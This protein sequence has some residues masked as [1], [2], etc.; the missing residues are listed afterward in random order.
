MIDLIFYLLETGVKLAV[1]VVIGLM[2]L[3]GLISWLNLNPFGWFAYNVRR[4]TEPMVDPLRRNLFA[5]QT[6]RD[7]APLLLVL[8]VLVVGYFLLG[9]LGQFRQMIG[10]SL[11][12]LSALAQG[13]PLTGARYLLGGLAL[14]IIAVVI[15]CIIL[16]VIF[17]WVGFYGNWLSRLVTRVS[18]PVLNPF[19]RMIPPIGALDI[20]PIVAI[21]ILYLLS[22]AVGAILLS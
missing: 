16:Q 14:G 15:T 19:R 13:S 9:L 7:I 1:G 22:A 17:S 4:M 20:S 12:G 10:Y 8:F 5:L 6:R 11:V 18:E 21:L 3:R 2:L